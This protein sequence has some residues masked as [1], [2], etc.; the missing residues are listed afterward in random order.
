MTFID[1]SDDEGIFG[2][3]LEFVRDESNQTGD[4]PRR[5]RFLAELLKKLHRANERSEG[6]S[7]TD[8]IR[9]LKTI[10]DSIDAEFKNDPAVIHIADCIQE[11]ERN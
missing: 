4:D 11:L 6:R 9:H 7:K 10:Y 2:L 5:R 8:L 3:L 1:W